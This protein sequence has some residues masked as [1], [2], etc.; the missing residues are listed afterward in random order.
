MNQENNAVLIRSTAPQGSGD[1][2]AG[3]RRL[4]T[5]LAGALREAYRLAAEIHGIDL[6]RVSVEAEA[7]V[8]CRPSG[9]AYSGMRAEISLRGLW[10]AA[11]AE[12]LRLFVERLAPSAHLFEGRLR[13]ELVIAIS[14]GSGVER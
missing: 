14:S 10:D 5:G 13:T 2:L 1:R 9:L 11:D 8:I 3:A 12:R 6:D 7:G 4:L